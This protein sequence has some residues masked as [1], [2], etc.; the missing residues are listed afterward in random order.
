MTWLVP[1]LIF[2][3][4]LGVVLAFGPTYAY[5]H[6]GALLKDEP[7]H[8]EFFGRA[9]E[10]VSRRL[11]FPATLSLAVTGFAIMAVTSYPITNPAA[12]WLQVSIVLYVLM[13][14]Y[15]A[16]VL[17]RLNARISDL[18]RQARAAGGPPPPE[19]MAMV[20]RTRRDGKL[21]GIVVLVILFLMVVKPAFPI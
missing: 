10:R 14:G 6:F 11:T 5:G 20:A 2:L 15:I 9:R 3:H 19:L 21:L 16:L 7:Q 1:Y 4:V 17:D 12:R 18:G 8:R 13:V